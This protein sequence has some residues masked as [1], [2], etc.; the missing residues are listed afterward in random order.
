[1]ATLTEKN[2]EVRKI[3]FGEQAKTTIEAPK[4]EKTTRTPLFSTPVAT[5]E[6]TATLEATPMQQGEALAEREGSF[7]DTVTN[8]DLLA[9]YYDA[10]YD[11]YQR[12]T[13]YNQEVDQYKYQYLMGKVANRMEQL[14][15]AWTATQ[16]FASG[17]FS[18]VGQF[19]TGLGRDLVATEKKSEEKLNEFNN[20]QYVKNADNFSKRLALKRELSG[21]SPI[22]K[23]ILESSEAVGNMTLP[24]LAGSAV[25]TAAS[26]ISQGAA[27]LMGFKNAAE[28]AKYG[29]LATN[30][31]TMG[32][33][34]AGNQMNEALKNGNSFDDAY[35]FGK[36]S[37]AMEV[38]SELIGGEFILSGI[39]G[40]AVKTPVG[41]LVQDW[42]NNSGITNKLAKG[43]INALSNIA[44]E[45]IEEGVMDVAD[46]AAKK[47]ILKDDS[48][49]QNLGK[50]IPQ[51][52]L[53]AI[54]PTVIL[55]GIGYADTQNY[56]NQQEKALKDAVTNNALLTK[57]QKG[58]LIRGIEQASS[59]AKIGLQENWDY[60]LAN[61]NR[62]MQQAQ[63]D[64]ITIG[65]QA[66]AVATDSSL[67][68]EEKTTQL[69]DL[70]SKWMPG[71]KE[72][73]TTQQILDETKPVKA[74]Y[75]NMDKI[76]QELEDAKSGDNTITKLEA[77]TD[78][79]KALQNMKLAIEKLTGKQVVFV[80]VESKGSNIHGFTP[81]DSSNI[82]VRVDQ[83]ARDTMAASFHE[84]GHHYNEMFPDLYKEYKSMYEQAYNDASDYDIEEAFGD[85]IGRTM[86]KQENVEGIDKVG[87]SKLNAFKKLGEALSNR[88][89]G[90]EINN[91]DISAY[92]LD[93]NPYFE[94]KN[95]SS[96]AF[97]K[98]VVDI[99]LGKNVK[100]VQKN[101]TKQQKTEEKPK[102]K[103]KQGTREEKNTSKREFLK[104]YSP[105]T[106]KTILQN[107]SNIV[108]TTY[109]ELNQLIDEALNSKSINKALHLGII[110]ENT[111]QEIKNKITNLPKNKSDYI[112]NQ[113]YDLVIRQSEIRHLKENKLRITNED[114]HDFIKMLPDI[115]TKS[116]TVSYD[117]NGNDEGL[118]F[119]K[120]LKDGKYVSFVL[121]SNK[122]NTFKVKSISMAKSD[123]ENKK[124]SLSPPSDTV[125]VSNNTP[126]ASGA[127]TSLIG[128]SIQQ[129]EQSVNKAKEKPVARL[130]PKKS[131]RE[132]FIEDVVSYMEN[133]ALSEANMQEGVSLA[134][135]KL[136]NSQF[137]K[138]Q[139]EF[140]VDKNSIDELY[141]SI[142]SDVEEKLGKE[143]K[144]SRT[145][146][147]GSFVLPQTDS[148]G[149]KLTNDQRDYFN[150]SFVRDVYGRL[151]EIYHGTLN[152]F[153]T[154]DMGKGFNIDAAY[155]SSN[156]NTT[157][158]W[159]RSPYR[160]IDETRYN[161]LTKEIEDAKT[162]KDV[163][164]I[165]K[166]ARLGVELTLHTYFSDEEKG[167]YYRLEEKWQD[168]EDASVSAPFGY[169]KDGGVTFEKE[170]ALGEIK[171]EAQR[172]VDNSYY[173]GGK[174]YVYLNI[175]KPLIVDAKGKPY[176]QVPFEGKNIN[177]ETLASIAKER[178]YDG[179]IIRDVLETDYEN[180]LTNDY[181]VFNPEQIKS[182]DNKH[183]TTNSDIRFSKISKDAFDKKLHKTIP[184][185]GKAPIQ[186]S[187]RYEDLDAVTKKEVD[188]D[189]L[190]NYFNDFVKLTPGKKQ[191]YQETLDNFFV[192]LLRGFTTEIFN[193]NEPLVKFD[194]T[195]AKLMKK[196]IDN[197]PSVLRVFDNFRRANNPDIMLQQ[198]ARGIRD[199]TTDEKM[200]KGLMEIMED[201]TP[202]LEEARRMG[203]SLKEAKA[204]RI[205]DFIDLGLA[206]R[207]TELY[208]RGIESGIEI[209]NANALIEMF[210]DD[211]KLHQALNDFRQIGNAILDL[212]VKQGV[213]SEEL[214][215]QMKKDNVLYF[216]MNRAF[217]GDTYYGGKGK[218]GS[219][220]Q[221]IFGIKGS[222]R[223]VENPLISA[224]GNW[225]RMLQV[226]ETNYMYTQ[227]F[228]VGEQLGENNQFFHEVKPLRKF[229]GQVTLEVFKSALNKQFKNLGYDELVNN[230]DYDQMYK[231][232]VPEEG[233]VQDRTLSFLVDGKRKYIQFYDND[234]GKPMYEVLSK[235][236]PSNA[237][238]VLEF[239]RVLNQGITYGATIANA[240]FAISNIAAD[241]G[242]SFIFNK[243]LTV[244]LISQMWDAFKLVKG[245]AGFKGMS[246][247]ETAQLYEKF[248]RSGASQ[249]TRLR[250]N[251]ENIYNTKVDEVFG[252]S[253]K[254]MFGKKG[255]G[256]SKLL[257]MATIIP[258]LSEEVGRF[259]NFVRAYK[260]AK[261]EG[262]SE[263]EAIRE[264][265][266]KAREWTQDFTIKGKFMKEFNKLVP[267]SAATL[268]GIYNF[269]RQARMH[270]VRV[271][272]RTTAL[273]AV[274]A[275]IMSMFDDDD[276]KY[277]EEMNK[278]KKFANYVIPNGTSEPIIIKKP[279]GPARVLI[280][281]AELTYNA[282]NGFIPEDKIEQEFMDWLTMSVEDQLPVFNATDAIPSTLQPIIENMLN[283]DFYYK[284]ELVNESLQK[285]DPENQYN[286]Y[287]SEVAKALGKVLD[288]SPIYIDNLIKGEFAGLGKQ[289]L[290]ISDN[291]IRE[292][293]GNQLPEKKKSEK[294]FYDKFFA[295]SLKSPESVSELYDRFSTLE[296]EKAEGRITAQQQR[297]YDKLN[298][299]KSVLSDINKEIKATRNNDKLTGEQKKEKIEQLQEFRTDAARYY[300]GKELINEKN[301]QKIVLLE[302]YPTQD[303][304]TYT[305]N[306]QK[307]KVSFASD[308]VKT[309]YAKMFK[310]E[311][312]KELEKL[313][314]TSEYQKATAMEKYQLEKDK[315]SSVRTSVTNEMKKIVYNRTK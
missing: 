283:K 45:M 260:I 147:D 141:S 40:Q 140:G 309:E 73:L 310:T 303:E 213:W 209:D 46:A 264:A 32:A 167:A 286:E 131:L 233:S 186:S 228:K 1:M 196:R 102:E 14:K 120:K 71:A 9:G 98:K 171:E 176:W 155:F 192:R 28:I 58:N 24:I 127:S 8:R 222:M 12:A 115:I 124:R 144:F 268:G 59:D 129:N 193:E 262:L 234:Y 97:E 199:M 105:N 95:I 81:K 188:Q 42:L 263:G 235:V 78:I 169:S 164:K 178:G 238:R 83:N 68:P 255:K 201:L 27:E 232:F 175:T 149:R 200:S 297:E 220:G 224:V 138:L 63:Q 93:T 187:L 152:H 5:Q 216:P 276:R 240:E 265:G 313:K 314:K 245:K 139:E 26:G 52:M 266:M 258:E 126:E 198:I 121:I 296:T 304:Y 108:V 20:K 163:F 137:S 177:T 306:K 299:G 16:D 189:E 246:E 302:Y 301:K 91:T 146:N 41:T 75:N 122:Q 287:T 207:A 54:L 153:F 253:S 194:N 133:K 85:F 208:K 237:S 261:N 143:I 230:L 118:Q 49:W 185:Y 227:L 162:I 242:A 279:Q 212:G 119:K 6:Q 23:G 236:G 117:K 99:L 226:I 239:F 76:S 7:L 69:K 35:K 101:S 292:A 29:S 39:A 100:N 217:D 182:I 114:I 25:G 30:L 135:D 156:I 86:S 132:R 18:G 252:R 221:G 180:S 36:V 256:E 89:F 166:R 251:F 62:T 109:D 94:N 125:K 202:T 305:V 206:E 214:V 55:G 249:G 60:M 72:K 218:N 168:E 111:I 33:S 50:S 231:I 43:G 136:N 244:P 134:L 280:N 284:S 274:A 17:F 142:Y 291:I 183:P 44:A 195:S 154:F 243:G 223:N 160:I 107:E 285:L 275:L 197:V 173:D 300:L 157:G 225:A 311:Y 172:I 19:E 2:D 270:P 38:A 170:N 150:N 308:K 88:Y 48:D 67:S 13:K 10:Y 271:L 161:Q 112:R 56:I 204:K 315:K 267:Y 104:D 165:L 269:G 215:D 293:S 210:K 278:V 110:D 257:K 103:A 191:K 57:E 65:N 145:S 4:E 289:T 294:Y 22:T 241:A 151:L 130:E 211:K 51:S 123:F 148:N 96:E 248:K 74:T 158:H 47:R 254:E 34:K 219:V 116:D 229:K 277:Y 179:V 79:N 273:M 272:S 21:Y 113:A 3:L 82:Y 87:K 247:S 184:G 84:I 282:A 92:N 106:L 31:G 70:E 159:A 312:E 190:T 250:N 290:D 53:G 66:L 61:L 203:L 64:Q 80:N 205:L 90:T 281:L 11:G 307:Y 128:S 15:S 77:V 174:H 295:N 288:F 298:S 259:G 181:I 37:G